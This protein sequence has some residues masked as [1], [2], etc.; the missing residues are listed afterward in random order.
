MHVALARTAASIRILLTS[1]V[2]FL[3]MFASAL[4]AQTPSPGSLT[5]A[6][7]NSHE[8][9]APSANLLERLKATAQASPDFTPQL[10]SGPIGNGLNAADPF[11]GG[12]TDSIILYSVS[13]L[14]IDSPLLRRLPD[15]TIEAGIGSS[16]TF[17][18]SQRIQKYE[19]RLHQVARLTTAPDLFPHGCTDPVTGVPSQP[20]AVF[21]HASDG[22]FYAVVA[23]PSTTNFRLT[24]QLTIVHTVGNPISSQPAVTSTVTLNPNASVVLQGDLAVGDLNGDG[25]LD[26]VALL[27]DNSSSGSGSANNSLAILLNAGNG[28]LGSPSY[29][30]LNVIPVSL[31]ITDVNGD[32]KLDIVVLGEPTAAGGTQGMEV[33][34]GNG[35]GTF[36]APVMGPAN[37]PQRG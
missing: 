27:T 32:G 19:D 22:N 13:P 36:K 11:F 1:L 4:R 20:G 15:C 31:L 24:N 37:F 30:P 33:F 29:I 16:S 2:V 34:L 3:A 9:A 26:V 28:A 14:V 12:T 6:A 17:Q 35:D 5:K 25:Q 8:A 23:I 10:Q 7:A 21:G 18:V